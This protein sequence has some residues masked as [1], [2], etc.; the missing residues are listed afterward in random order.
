MFWRLPGPPKV[1]KITA[2]MAIIMGLGLLSYI[3]LAFR[4][5]RGSHLLG[6]CR[7][8]DS[9]DSESSQFFKPPFPHYVP[10]PQHLCNNPRGRP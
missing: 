7:R 6:K 1:C 8:I 10:Y 9:Y 2:F 5:I 3:L 4:Y